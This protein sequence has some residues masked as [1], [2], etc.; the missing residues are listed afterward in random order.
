MEPSL[1]KC[2]GAPKL[3]QT[4]YNFSNSNGADISI[5]VTIFSVS[6]YCIEL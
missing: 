6:R 1:G 2:V 5:S 3:N 4:D